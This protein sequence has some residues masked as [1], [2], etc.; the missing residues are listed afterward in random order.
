MASLDLRKIFLQ[1]F[2]QELLWHTAQR[3]QIST[4]EREQETSVQKNIPETMD[5]KSSES[6]LKRSTR[7]IPSTKLPIN[8]TNIP[9]PHSPLLLSGKSMASLPYKVPTIMLR[10]R[11]PPPKVYLA[12]PTESWLV[13]IKSLSRIQP[14]ISDPTITSI[15][16]PG[17]GLPIM[18]ARGTYVQSTPAHFTTEE[19]K[20][21]V[22]EVSE[23]TKIPLD[24][25][26]IFKAAIGNIIITAVISEFVGTRFIIQKKPRANPNAARPAQLR[27]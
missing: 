11:A 1:Q 20:K 12:P 23:R 5:E 6:T 8:K 7:P 16:C 14:L 17:P 22:Q 26:G 15:E 10:Q 27:R 18:I 13:D 2:V 24:A 25:S 3:T 19:V 4:E 21:I 9:Q